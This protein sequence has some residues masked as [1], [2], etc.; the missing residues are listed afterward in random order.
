MLTQVDPT[1]LGPAGKCCDVPAAG[2][3]N[4][5]QLNISPVRIRTLV[6]KH[7]AKLQGSSPASTSEQ[8]AT[9]NGIIA[10]DQALTWEGCGPP[11]AQWLKPWRRRKVEG[12]FSPS[13]HVHVYQHDRVLHLSSHLFA[14]TITIS[15]LRAIQLR[16]QSAENRNPTWTSNDYEHSTCMV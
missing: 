6:W 12:S 5:P 4:R 11:I 13:M 14:I 9:A 2:R 10:D 15:H 16:A 3:E 8:H 7:K 1:S